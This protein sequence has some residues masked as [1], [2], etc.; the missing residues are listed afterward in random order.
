M[1]SVCMSYRKKGGN[2][3][4]FPEV[5]LIVCP[6]QISRQLATGGWT[7][8]PRWPWQS[9][10]VS[11]DV[12]GVS[13]SLKYSKIKKKGI[14]QLP[15]RPLYEIGLVS[16]F[17]SFTYILSWVY[18]FQIFKTERVT[19]N[20]ELFLCILNKWLGHCMGTRENMWIHCHVTQTTLMK[21]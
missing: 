4:G 10:S 9:L 2:S 21:T 19:C 3:P 15:L 1:A 11:F 5:D 14:V 20:S 16:L 18:L 6:P 13:W 7:L 17:G 12:R 8:W